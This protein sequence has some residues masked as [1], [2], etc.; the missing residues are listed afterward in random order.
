MPRCGNCQEEV[1]TH[2]EHYQES[3]SGMGRFHCFRVKKELKRKIEVPIS[4]GGC[5][6]CGKLDEHQMHFNESGSGMGGYYSCR[7]EYE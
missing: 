5:P 4:K 6:N 2:D 7:P 1:P 3:G